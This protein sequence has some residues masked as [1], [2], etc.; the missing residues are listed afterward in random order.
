T[1][2]TWTR[3]NRAAGFV[4]HIGRPIA[5]TQIYLL[6]PHGQPVPL[7]VTGEIHIAGAGV[8]RGYLNRPELTAERFLS[9]PFSSLPDARMYKTGDLGRWLPD[10]NLEYLGRNDF[11]V[12][13]RGFRI[14]PGEIEARLMQCDGVREAVVLAREY[15]PHEEPIADKN[16]FHESNSSGNNSHKNTAGQ[17]RLVAYILPQPG[18][19]LVP[20][21]LR[22]QLAQYLA[23]YMLP[24]AYIVLENFPLTPNGKLDR[25]ALPA[26][27][28]SAFIARGYEAPIGEIETVL[29]EI[30]QD[31]LGV[32]QVGR[33]DHFFE[34]GGHSLMIVSL[35]E[36]LHHLGW[37][38][39]M[40]RVFAA[41][42]LAELAQTILAYQD[43]NCIFEVPSALIPEGCTAITPDML[44]LVSLSQTEIDTLVEATSGGAGN[45]QDIYP[46]APLQ[47]GILFHHLLQTQGDD[48]LLQS[49]LAF[50]TRERL[51]AFLSALQQVIDR[52]DILR[53]A[54]CWQGLTQP[55]QV[56][57]RQAPLPVKVFTPATTE[58]IPS[59]LQAC[60]DPRRHRLDL[61]CAPLFAADIAHDPAQEEWLLVLRFHHLVSDHT[62]LELVFAEIAQ[63]LQGKAET[64][65]TA[66]P[67]RNFIAQTLSIPA[68]VHETYFRARLA[69]IDEPTAPFGIL[70]VQ[71]GSNPVSQAQLPLDPALAETIRAQARRLKVS[72]SVLFHVAWAQV[73]AQTCGRDD[74]VFG[75]VLLGRLQGGAGADRILGMFI[76]TLPVRVS[77]NKH[78]VQEVIQATYRNLMTLLEHEQTPLVLAQSCSGV[79]QSMPLFSTLLNYRHSQTGKTET[80]AGDT[81]WAGMRIIAA[82]ERSNY[83]ITLSVDDL[84]TDFHLTAQTVDGIDPV[85]INIYLVTAISGLIEALVRDPQQPIL[86]IPILPISERQQ[87]LVDFNAT[88]A[89][90]PQ[91][92]LIH[93]LF[94][95]QAAQCPEAI[96]VVFEEQ[97]LSYG[98]LNCRANRLAH[99]LISLGV[100]A[101]DRVAIC[102]ERSPDMVVGLL[103]ILKAGG[104]YVPLDPAYPAE[105]LTYMLEDATPVV[106]LTQAVIQT[107]LVDLLN[108]PVP[109]VV[110]DAQAALLAIQPAHNPDAQTLGLTSHHLAY[111]IYTSGSTGLPK[112]VMVEHRGLT[113][114]IVNQQET[115]ALTPNSRV[116]QFASNSF[117]ACIWECC[118]ALMAGASLHL[119]SRTELLPG[120]ALLQTL[121]TQA[122][123]HVLLPPVALSAL[124]AVP[125]TLETLLVG[126]EAC[127]SSQVKRWATGRRMIN[128]YGPTENTVCSAMYLCDSQETEAPP[129]G[130]PIANTQ[131]YILD[132][133]GQPVPLGAVGEIYI[134]GVGVARG[135]LNRP[136]LTAE[137][138]LP[139]PFSADPGAR[140]YKTGDLGR[141]RSDGNIDYLGRNDFQVKLR[142]FR[143]E[144]GEI[145]AKLMQCHGVKEAVVLVRED[146][147]E[148]LHEETSDEK[149]GN[150]KRL[151]AYLLAA[152]GVE[153][154]PAELRQQLAQHLADYML[155]SAFVTLESFPLTPNGK[156]DRQA[157]PVPDLSAVI[158][159]GYEAPVGE[160][161]IIL[162]KIWQDLLRVERVGRHDHF[163][164]LGGH[165]LFAVQ[166]ASRVRQELAQELPLQQLFA[167]P[168]L[169]DLAQVLSDTSAD[170]PATEQIAISPAERNQPL[171]LSFAQ[172]RL[173][174][175]D[176]LDPAA[177]LAY[178][179]PVALRLTG[180]LNQHALSAALDCL[181]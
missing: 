47:E 82:E 31:L 139:D 91:D 154:V 89:D 176:Q 83:P 70:K 124:D 167:R 85:R 109:T 29:A 15:I 30:W 166:L 76:N 1:Y 163:F 77:L 149:I 180:Q 169:A 175:L 13:L 116:L 93:Q 62:T 84:G 80:D 35:I 179:I 51:D 33:Y 65:P 178:H 120:T 86:P 23:D 146:L 137:R 22:Q 37:Q 5:N 128:A 140:M 119:A 171:P 12:K 19:E 24:S 34:L 52:H 162:A 2:S 168:L 16:D 122:I 32:E 127:S 90:F 43:S 73:L 72:P 138:F 11:Q 95:I 113:N 60:T 126:G 172:Q 27:D 151:V 36:R 25:Q 114:L 67:Y 112:G 123:T 107:T 160:T 159:R 148:G 87:L 121:E 161:E 92:T 117:D 147:R 129:I 38:L 157:L 158:A 14:E 56:V 156:L 46:L 111:V 17:K 96:A 79:A 104:A 66:L 4:S 170:F 141:W 44:P 88:Q 58:D 55:V 150:Q 115:L 75:S 20:A 64:L 81:I 144:P 153:L 143:I 9:D 71:N 145:E 42:V 7:G 53:T 100:R 78:N 94:E 45:I 155:P 54:V 57:W 103:A 102:V 110:L 152:E 164:E 106:L 136:E 133:H 6:D 50:D 99:Y 40:R 26:P 125:E 3:M 28:L 118:M 142:G 134:A 49:L 131:I 177:S 8:A 174:F 18:I 39:D 105:R 41:P 98:E 61:N 69:D 135:Y 101:D 165:S 181:I 74:V 63:I 10:G 59:Q 108:R 48:Y 173:W 130:R 21:E 132:P 97:V 68:A